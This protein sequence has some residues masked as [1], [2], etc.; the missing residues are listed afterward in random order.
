MM[1]A[2]VR[3]LLGWSICLAGALLALAGGW[4]IAIYAWGVVDVWG[5]PDT[6]WIFWGLVFLLWGL[7]FL[8]VGLGAVIAGLQIL[9]K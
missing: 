6:S 1:R 5:E 7:I 3:R 2:R 8:G 9:R 4:G